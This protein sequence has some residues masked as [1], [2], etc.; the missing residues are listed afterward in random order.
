MVLSTRER[1]KGFLFSPSK[2]FDNSKEDTLGDAF[3]YFVVLLAIYAVLFSI[4]VLVAF[5]AMAWIVGPWAAMLG[6]TAGPLLAVSMLVLS[7]IAGIIAV[8]IMGLWMH[9]WVY[10][11]GGR[12]GVT[13]TI[14]ALMYGATPSYLLG[15]IP[16]IGIIAGIWAL[17]V[18]IIGIRQLHELSTGKA[19]LAFILAI[20][21]PGIV[22]AIVVF[23]A[24]ITMPELIPELGP[25][26]GGY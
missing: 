19:V 16:F 5:S 3:K 26:F 9:I 11:V 20:I 21:I 4:M 8:F 10:V 12:K 15:W 7:L 2:T 1:I 22:A 17:V 6:L 24:L 23:A 13:Q 25:R 18:E 14:K